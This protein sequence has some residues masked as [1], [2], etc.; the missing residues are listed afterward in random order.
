MKKLILF[1]CMAFVVCACSK[2]NGV[3]KSGSL[4][5]SQSSL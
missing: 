5:P 3:L 1:V 4:C 2:K